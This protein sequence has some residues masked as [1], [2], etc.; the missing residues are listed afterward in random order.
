MTAEIAWVRWWSPRVA[1]SRP[2]LVFA[3]AW[4]ADRATDRRPRPRAT[5][6]ACPQLRYDAMHA[7]TTQ[8]GAAIA[9]LRHAPDLGPCLR[10]GGEHLRTVN[11]NT[12]T[13]GAGPGLV[14]AHRQSPAPG[15]L[16]RTRPGSTRPAARMAGRT[17]LGTRAPGV[18]TRQN[19]RHRIGAS[20]QPPAA[21]LNTLWQSACWKAEQSLAPSA[22]IQTERHD[23]RSAFA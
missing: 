23:A 18:P 11:G 9:V 15:A 13:F 10:I 19:H 22:P 17:G 8:P 2:G 16:A 7:T 4:P 5:C 3:G 1:R 14:R 20:P 12:G 21:K 6:R